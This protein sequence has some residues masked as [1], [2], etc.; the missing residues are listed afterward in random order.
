MINK[1]ELINALDSCGFAITD[2]YRFEIEA[3]YYQSNDWREK[4]CFIAK[5]KAGKGNRGKIMAK[6]TGKTRNEAFSNLLKCQLRGADITTA[7]IIGIK[8]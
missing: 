1:C 6:A 3:I 8:E 2:N 7:D 4:N 5:M